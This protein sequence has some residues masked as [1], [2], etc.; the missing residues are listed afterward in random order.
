MSDLTTSDIIALIEQEEASAYGI[1]DAQL[2]KERADSI[3]YY[4]GRPFGNEIEGRSQV[5]S[6]DVADTIE[7][8]LPA[9]LKV[10]TAGDQVVKFEPRGPEDMEPAEQETDYIN[11]LVM[12]KNDGFNTFYTW[13]KDALLTKVGYVKCYWEES[14]EVDKET[15]AGLSDDELTLLLQDPE[16]DPLEHTAYPDQQ[17]DP[18]MPA[19]MLHDVK[20][21][22]KRTKGKVEICPVAPESM[23][24]GIDNNKVSLREARF[25]QHREVKTV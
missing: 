23:M 22:T 11:Y 1:N 3:D 17:F 21:Q 15:Y 20:V 18:A 25:V 14:E 4:L 16:I 7:S 8:V 13:F 19:P 10:F 2:A 24:V 5:A 12:E 9:L 6:T